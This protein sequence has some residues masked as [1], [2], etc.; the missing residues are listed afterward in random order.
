MFNF[1]QRPDSGS[2][3]LSKY[4][5]GVGPDR[6]TVGGALMNPTLSASQISLQSN[7]TTSLP[8][9]IR[10]WSHGWEKNFNEGSPLFVYNKDDDPRMNTS[11]DIPCLNYMLQSAQRNMGRKDLRID[12]DDKYF[13][14]D[15][16]FRDFPYGFFGVVR[17]DLMAN[18]SLQK[19]YNC[20][21]FGRSMIANVFSGKPLKRGDH[22]GLA[23]VKMDV[24]KEYSVFVQPEGTRLPAQV[25][26]NIAYQ[27]VGTKNG[28]LCGH[29]DE[30]SLQFVEGRNRVG[31]Q[32]D[33]I[34]KEI[35]R[36]IPLG[37]VSHAVARIPSVG[38]IKEALRSQDKF[39]LLPRVEILL[40]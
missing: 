37:V 1:N 19:L 7:V 5:R 12:D 4:K 33:K 38:K 6:S 25:T 26:R 18:S 13:G 11:L 31:N 22:V 21:V 34:V 32:D 40:N 35:C 28:L 39:T 29:S 14:V 16:D 8:L 20:D 24:H 36:L 15:A 10:P 30:P 3:S 9:F 23:V 17:N 27:I 2:S